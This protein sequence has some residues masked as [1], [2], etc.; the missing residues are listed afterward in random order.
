MSTIDAF[1]KR[2]EEEIQNYIISDKKKKKKASKINTMF[3]LAMT[4][5]MFGLGYITIP[6]FV[7]SLTIQGVSLVVNAK[8]K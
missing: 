3:G 6:W 8:T 7:F 5:G 1:N 2:V 4:G